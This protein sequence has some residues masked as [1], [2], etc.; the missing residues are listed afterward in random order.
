MPT[1]HI[2]F[3]DNQFIICSEGYVSEK[4]TA[5]HNKN[6]NEEENKKN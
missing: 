2:G 6:K 3:M 4:A 5:C 1:L